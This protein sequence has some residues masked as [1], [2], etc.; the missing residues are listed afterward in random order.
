MKI[1]YTSNIPAPY[2]V[3]FLNELGKYANVES[4]FEKS[5][6]NERNPN[7]KSDSKSNFKSKILMGIP[8]KTDQSFAPQI[9]LRRFRKYDFIIVTN[10][11]TPTGILL[12][13]YLKLLN[14]P[15]ILMS[16]GGFPRDDNKILRKIKKFVIENSK[17]CL[18]GSNLGIDFYNFY[19]KQKKDIFK[20][21]FTSIYK[22]EI[23][24]FDTMIKKTL[25]KKLGFKYE[26][27]VITVGQM[28]PRKGHDVLMNAFKL[29][30]NN[31]NFGL[32]IVGG[33]PNK[34]LLD[35]KNELGLNNIHFIDFLSKKELLEFY[36]SSDLF[37]LAT[38]EDEY[39]LV[40]NEAMASGLPVI[41]TSKCGGGTELIQNQ[42][43]GYIINVDDVNDLR[44]KMETILF[45]DELAIRMSRN[46]ISKIKDYTYQKW[47]KSIF[48]LLS[49]F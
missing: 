41:T 43:N 10:F 35:L 32:V 39:G 24:N 4:I 36:K 38:R 30:S 22:N 5:K 28:I 21:P 3:N 14:I 8:Y 9:I 49:K 31:Y 47:A 20:Y 19:G 34:E 23:I 33:E 2:T 7:W 42:I 27:M 46:N 11:F 18:S 29:I 37:V 26:K 45:D 48:Q 15:Y 25:K 12:I 40:I 6:S 16:E 13:L 1:L 17:Y 44:L